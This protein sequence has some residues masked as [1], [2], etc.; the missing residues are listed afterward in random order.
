KYQAIIILDGIIA[1]LYRPVEGCIHDSTIQKE[2]GM[3]E[4]LNAHTYTL[5]RS[6]LQVNGYPAYSINEYL[7]SPFS[8]TFITYDEREWNTSMSRV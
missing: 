7:I 3:S 2:S 4:I 5:D 1:Y 6:P 8:S